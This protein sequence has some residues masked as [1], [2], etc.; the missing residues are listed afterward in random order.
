[1]R[2]IIVCLSWLVWAGIAGATEYSNTSSHSETLFQVNGVYTFTE[3]YDFTDGNILGG[4]ASRTYHYNRADQNPAFGSLSVISLPINYGGG[5][6]GVIIYHFIIPVSNAPVKLSALLRLG[7]GIR[8]AAELD[9]L[10]DAAA[11]IGTGPNT[12]PL[13]WIFTECSRPIPQSQLKTSI[14]G[15]TSFYLQVLNED[16]YQPAAGIDRLVITSEITGEYTHTSLHSETLQQV[17]GVYAFTEEYDF[18]N[19]NTL[20]DW[21]SRTYQYNRADQ[22]PAFGTSAIS[23]PQNLGSSGGTILYHFVIPVENAPVKLSALL[24]LGAGI[25]VAAELDGLDEAAAQMGTGPNTQTLNNIFTECTRP[26]PPSQLKTSEPGYTSFYLQIL[27]EGGYQPAAGIDRLVITSENTGEYTNSV[28]HSETLSLADG[29]FT[30]IEDYTSAGDKSLGGWASK[31]YQYQRIN[32]MDFGTEVISFPTVPPWMPELAPAWITYHFI[33]PI[34]SSAVISVN[35]SALLREGAAIKVAATWDQLGTATTLLRGDHIAGWGFT[36][37]S[38]TIPV[39]QLDTTVPGQISF[40]LKCFNEGNYQPAAGMD[41]LIITTGGTTSLHSETLSLTNGSCTFIEDY[42]FTS[43]DILGVWASKTYQYNQTQQSSAM[44]TNAITLPPH[45]GACILYNF[46]IPVDNATVNYSVRLRCYSGI[47]IAPELSQLNDGSALVALGANSM[48]EGWIFYEYSGTIPSSQLNTS[49]PGKTS[50][51]VKVLNELDFMDASGIDQLIVT[52]Y[53]KAEAPVFTPDQIFISDPTPISLSSSTPGAR[54]Y[55]TTDGTTPT[56]NSILYAD[57]IMLTDETKLKAVAVADYYS[58]SK[59]STRTFRPRI[60]PIVGCY[61]L[62][63]N[64]STSVKFQ[65]MR[66]AGFTHNLDGTSYLSVDDAGDALDRA[67]EEGMKMFIVPN[68]PWAAFVTLIQNHSALEAYFLQDEPTTYFYTYLAFQAQ[69][70]QYFDPNHWCYVNMLPSTSQSFYTTFLNTVP[71]TVLSFDRYPIRTNGLDPEFFQNLE[72][73][74][75]A[76]NEAGVP[77]WTY[78]LATAHSTPS[79]TYPVPTIEHLRFQIFSNLA[80]G[81]QGIQYFTYAG[82]FDASGNKNATYYLI[83]SMNQEI[84]GLSNVFLDAEVH[85]VGHTGS[86]IPSG[87]TRYVAEDPILNLTT[88][89]SAGAVV[90]KLINGQTWYLAVVNRDINNFMTLNL[91]VDTSRGISRVFKDG[92][93]TALSSGTVQYTVGPGDIV[94][95]KWDVLPGDANLDDTVDVG[96]LGILAATY[97]QSGKTWTMGDFN[98]DGKVDVGDLGILAANYGAGTGATLDFA[99][100]VA[101]AGLTVDGNDQA[102]QKDDTPITSTLGCSSVGLP[103]VMGLFFIALMLGHLKIKE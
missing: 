19:Q 85:N 69:T 48:S 26:I 33:I 8:V 29:T 102:V 101:A 79:A 99:A 18:P 40:F 74:S 103:L 1:M 57:P 67:A 73:A 36:D 72:V 15:Y 9:G 6:G 34:D 51:Y 66:E 16:G 32:Q 14:P 41:Q 75:T 17:N 93:A 24:L 35:C 88:T 54:I 3:E 25:R 11:K 94:I 31:T 28:L 23:L 68:E 42:N 37:C 83:Q 56:S 38:G 12:Q 87:T 76:A 4:W 53:P 58:F 2:K 55:Y 10:D 82:L 84:K 64:S 30:F 86:S 20:G 60:I 80:Y 39:S 5:N 92:S 13:G 52:T 59:V 44:A 45:T 91:T 47:R 61:G 22:H 63:P 77:L 90:S 27:N 96:D 71:V 78:V 89:G 21:A 62:E 97:G 50:F 43:D 65:E 95:L 7:A 81:V 100:D 70:I 98:Y 49:V 46:I